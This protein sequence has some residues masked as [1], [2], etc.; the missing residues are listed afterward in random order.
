MKKLKIAI[1]AHACRAGGGL[2]GT[3][4]LLR[5]LKNVA[6]K[7]RFLLVCSANYGYEDIELPADSE[8]FVYKGGHSL[9]ERYWFETITLP[10]IVEGFSPNVIFGAGNTGLVKP[11]VPQAIFIQQAYLLYDKRYYSDIHFLLKLRMEL[12]RRQIE[13]SLAATNIVF[14]QTPIVG[15][16]FSKRFNYPQDNINLLRWPVPEGIK[17]SANLQVPSVIQKSPEGFYVLVMTRHMPHR[18]PDILIPLC[19]RYGREIRSRGIRFITTIE[20]AE[21]YRARR[22]LKGISKNH[23]EDIIINVGSLSR[24]EVLKYFTY[25]DVLWMPTT[26]ETLCLPYLEAMVMGV[27]ILAPD[28]D[29]ARY[30][31]GKAALFYDPWDIESLFSKVMLIREDACLK[32]QLGQ[33]GKMELGNKKKFSEN[34]DEAASDVLMALRGLAEGN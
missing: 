26:L 29:F 9:I 23:L 20:A 13:K 18:N 16:R 19:T 3:L 12:L 22:F 32:E 5:A 28:I 30:V 14:T 6:Q 7:E 11:K 17:P 4:D 27:P 8:F 21:G 24:E 10:R 33:M 1:I 25:S 31:C 15:Q 2:I 34:W